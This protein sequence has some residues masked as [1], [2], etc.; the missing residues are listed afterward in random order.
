[1][2]TAP[3]GLDHAVGRL[4]RDSRV[5]MGHLTPQAQKLVADF[6]TEHALQGEWINVARRFLGQASCAAAP[7]D[8]R[9]LAAGFGLVEGSALRHPGVPEGLWTDCLP[10]L[11]LPCTASQL[12]TLTSLAM[13]TAALNVIA[14]VD[15]GTG[16]FVDYMTWFW[17][18]D[19][20]TAPTFGE[21]IDSYVAAATVTAQ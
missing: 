15:A 6:L 21:L 2:T 16:L 14:D 5:L 20:L 17:N 10:E 8:R 11:L 12:P 7:H 13:R 19:D 9:R 18:T 3:Q 1:M 4:L